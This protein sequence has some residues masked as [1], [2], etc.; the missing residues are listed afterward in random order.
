MAVLHWGLAEKNSAVWHCSASSS[1]W[2]PFSPLSMQDRSSTL[3]SEVVV[4]LSCHE[5]RGKQVFN[6]RLTCYQAGHQDCLPRTSRL[7][8]SC[9]GIKLVLLLLGEGPTI[10]WERKGYYC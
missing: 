3:S 6:Y 2:A 1:G 10:N 9:G 5:M 8:L 4:L 7:F